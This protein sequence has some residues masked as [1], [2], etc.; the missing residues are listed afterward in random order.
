LEPFNKKKLDQLNFLNNN[1]KNNE[2]NKN[3]FHKSNTDLEKQNSYINKNQIFD[4][5]LILDTETTGLDENKEEV[6]EVGSILFHVPSKT[7]LSQVSFL[8]PVTKNEAEHINGISS[9]VSNI[10]QPWEKGLDFFLSLVDSSDLIIAHNA[11]FDKKW[12]G[13]GRLP[14]LNKKWLCSLEDINWSFK[15]SLKTRPSVTDLALSFEIPVWNLHRALSDCY[16]LS[17]VFKKCEDLE[18]ILI[19]ASEPR[20]LYKAIV[21]YEE[22]TLAKNAGFRWNSPVQGAWTRKL[23]EKEAIKLDFEVQILNV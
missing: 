7:V 21:S 1:Y 10:S 8:L 20:Y 23:S 12:F 22:R 13:K 11:E 16:Y 6:I 9:D 19:K 17:E 5:V 18:D 3:D 14:L 2:I 4:K 15:K